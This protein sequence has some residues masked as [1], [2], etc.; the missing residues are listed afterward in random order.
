MAQIFPVCQQYLTLRISP[1]RIR[2]SYRP[3]YPRL[4]HFIGREAMPSGLWLPLAS[5]LFQLQPRQLPPGIL[6]LGQAG[7]E[8]VPE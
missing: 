8:K 2:L 5:I 6:Y 4:R 1:P 7:I 3:D